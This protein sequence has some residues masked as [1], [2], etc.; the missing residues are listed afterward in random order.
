MKKT[1]PL[2]AI[3]F[4]V[5]PLTVIFA[6]DI[7]VDSRIVGVMVYPDSVLVTREA[8][9]KLSVGLNKIIFENIIPEVDENS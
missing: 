9:A 3:C 2:S 5:M 1:I 8:Q 7:I 4:L 6:S